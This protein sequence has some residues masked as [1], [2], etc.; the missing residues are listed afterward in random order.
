MG[1][2][3]FDPRTGMLI[4]EETGVVVEE[5]IFS[6]DLERAYGMEDWLARRHHK[7]IKPSMH[8]YSI[9][10]LRE[11]VDDGERRMR[12]IF[13]LVSRKLKLLN[14]PNDA[15][16]EVMHY[17]RKLIK[18]ISWRQMTKC[19]LAVLVYLVLRRRMSI[20]FS[21]VAEAFEC[22]GASRVLKKASEIIERIPELREYSRVERVLRKIYSVERDEEV[23]RRAEA[24]VN[25][26]R[27]FIETHGV[28]ESTLAAAILLRARQE[29][30]KPA[31]QRMMRKLFG[32]SDVSIRNLYKRL[33][34]ET[35][36][37]KKKRLQASN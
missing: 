25:K 29:L 6:Y 35:Y 27:D 12:E 13:S 22:N 2:L 17:L 10:T 1:S 18:R 23:L 34:G 33:F 16:S 14:V 36:Q 32:A 15:Y 21:R 9:G 5:N 8:D 31:T 24:I 37:E 3:V 20:D 4:D 7:V 11:S 26:L 19:Y 30:G 28:K